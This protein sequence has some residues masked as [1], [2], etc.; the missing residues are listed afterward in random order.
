MM[1]TLSRLRRVESRA[2]SNKLD[3]GVSVLELTDEGFSLTVDLYKPGGSWRQIVSVHPSEKAAEA[4][5]D[6]MV[7]KYKPPKPDPVL[8]IL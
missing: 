8:I 7:E 4:E 3:F 6:R 2:A 5:F 1:N